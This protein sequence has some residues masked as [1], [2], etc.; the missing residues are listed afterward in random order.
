NGQSLFNGTTDSN[1]QISGLTEFIEFIAN[2]S[3]TYSESS[4][5]N[6]TTYNNMT[7]YTFYANKTS[8][9]T[10]YTN[11]TVNES[12]T[13]TLFLNENEPPLV[14]LSGPVNNTGTT[15]TTIDFNFTA[16]DP[17]GDLFLNASLWANFTG[18]FAFVAANQTAVAAG[19]GMNNITRLITQ[20]VGRYIWNVQVCDLFGN[21]AFNA[22]NRTLRI[23]ASNLAPVINWVNASNVTPSLIYNNSV[24]TICQANVTDPDLD[25]KFVNFT[26]IA[27]SGAVL[28]NE[29]NSTN[30]SL[31]DIYN[32]TNFTITEIGTYRCVVRAFD[33]TANVTNSSTFAVLNNPPRVNLSSPPNNN[34]TD[35]STIDFNFTTVDPDGDLFLNASLWANFTGTFAFV[36]A[37]QTAVAAGPATNNITWFIVQGNG[38]YIWNIQ[39]CDVRGDCA[40]NASN[41]LLHINKTGNLNIP[42]INWVNSSNVTPSVIYNNSIG[43]ICQANVTDVD[44]GDTK[45]VN[46]TIIAPSGAVLVNEVN[47]TNVSLGDIYNSTNF[48][49]TEIGNYRCIVRAFD[50]TDNVTNSTLFRVLNIPSVGI[51]TPPNQSILNS[52]MWTIQASINETLDGVQ[53]ATYRITN[54]TGGSVT[55]WTALSLVSGTIYSGVWLAYY[56][57][58]P[59][60]NGT[61]N[62]T[63]N[64]S[65]FSSTYNDTSYVQV[66]KVIPPPI[67]PPPP[68]DENLTLSM[69]AEY[70]CAGEP[71]T[72]R[73][74][75]DNV[76]VVLYWSNFG[77]LEIV[78]AGSTGAGNSIIFSTISAQNGSYEADASKS[79]YRDASTSFYLAACAPPP[80]DP[81]IDPTC[82][83]PPPCD[84]ATDPTCPPP[85]DPATDPT[86]QPPPCDPATDPTCI[87]PP[88]PCESDGDCPAGSECAGGSC[89]FIPIGDCGFVEGHKW[90]DYECCSDD[91]CETG[92]FC[93]LE[94]HACLKKPII[95]PPPAFVCKQTCEDDGSAACCSGYCEAGVCRLKPPAPQALTLPGGVGVKSGCA[96]LG[97]DLGFLGCNF[98]WLLLL[99]LSALAGYTANKRFSRL[100]GAA[101]LLLPL[102]VALI[103][104]VFIGI[105]LALVE[106]ALLAFISGRQKYEGAD[107]ALL[108]VGSEPEKEEETEPKP[109]P[110][111]LG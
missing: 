21:C 103:S 55:G 66:T 77:P 44:A 101:F 2:G 32:S 16:I 100:H 26:I 23:L 84:P 59:I 33:G 45:Y 108:D 68:P 11:A 95:P 4:Q 40:F 50:G 47:S 54:A 24:G 57:S 80:C 90:Y 37:N 10:N 83:P 97:V 46:F 12:K 53:S 102:F 98:L 5:Q 106:L 75:T 17:D 52:S 43:T 22:S 48:T 39:V 79:G 64:A 29:V 58:Q 70:A 72:L 109:Q 76:N 82:M 49:I 85:C 65:S 9:R 89:E 38:T 87:P 107:E 28:V 31:G 25:D 15:N 81:L 7:N 14:N 105:L 94:N 92:Y 111:S 56:D 8:Y 110:S 51:L 3:F 63:I 13:I 1:G 93:D 19:P 60:S 96:G 41:R 36:A 61:Y 88:P 34:N 18:T 73:T 20:G 27:P 30:R 6:F 62:I 99:S 78:G 67:I 35:N 104:Y 42:V 69:S 74:S 91:Y 86:C 71:V